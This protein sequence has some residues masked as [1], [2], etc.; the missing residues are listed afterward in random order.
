V[1]ASPNRLVALALVAGFAAYAVIAFLTARGWFALL[2]LAAAAGLLAAAL[3]GIRA[4]RV[5]N[6]SAGTLWV[7]LGIA[8]LFAIGTPL[9]LLGWVAFDEV[10]LFASAVLQ[11]AT[12]L[13]ARR[14]GAPTLD[15][16]IPPTEPVDVTPRP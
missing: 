9:N 4:S 7:V 11:L 12:G 3:L 2:L 6:I 10:I 13:G 8:G 5:A 14:D 15:D 16:V 1:L